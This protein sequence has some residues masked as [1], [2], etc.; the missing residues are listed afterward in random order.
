MKVTLEELRLLR[1]TLTSHRLEHEKLVTQ[2]HALRES[3][4]EVREQIA[5]ASG[6]CGSVLRRSEASTPGQAYSACVESGIA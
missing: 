4:R 3:S 6:D 5:K 1:A 2:M